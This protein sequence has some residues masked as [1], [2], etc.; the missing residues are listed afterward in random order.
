MLQESF[1]W[2]P[3]K[4]EFR[5]GTAARAGAGAGLPELAVAGGSAAPER[6]VRGLRA[7]GVLGGSVPAAVGSATGRA[8]LSAVTQ[9]AF[10]GAFLRL[11][12]GG[13]HASF[14]Q[15]LAQ[16]AFFLLSLLVLYGTRKSRS[17]SWVHL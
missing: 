1:L 6:S 16:L 7:G 10:V 4:T 14:R 2:A 9:A 12:S 15:L 5:R 11:G 8:A 3:E 17:R 13:F